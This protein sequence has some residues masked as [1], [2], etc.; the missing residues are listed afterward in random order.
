MGYLVATPE[1]YQLL[2]HLP[3]FWP[4]ATGGDQGGS[5]G[6]CSRFMPN[7]NRGFKLRSVPPLLGGRSPAST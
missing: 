7:A 2:W 6:A 4:P 5:E 1:S 3:L